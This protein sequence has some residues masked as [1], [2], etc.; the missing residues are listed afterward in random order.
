LNPSRH[1]RSLVSILTYI[2][3]LLLYNRFPL[4]EFDIVQK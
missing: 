1:A 4:A 2:R 3:R